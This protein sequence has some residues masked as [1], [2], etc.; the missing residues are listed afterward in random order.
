MP[1]PRT[2]RGRLLLVALVVETVMLTLLVGNSL[3]LLQGSLGEQAEIHAAQM[4][5]VL[6]AALVAPMAQSDYA[7]VQAILNESS[8]VAGIAYLAVTDSQGRMVAISGW[9]RD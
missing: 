7:T 5:P 4:A 6:N 1:L 2:V 8:A 3:R 9:P